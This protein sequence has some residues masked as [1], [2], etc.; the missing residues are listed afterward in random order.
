MTKEL[1]FKN[2]LS[3]YSTQINVLLIGVRAMRV[4]HDKDRGRDSF[5]SLDISR[6]VTALETAHGWALEAQKH[7]KEQEDAIA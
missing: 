2:K 1:H 5:V 7:L 6:L 4:A 3:I